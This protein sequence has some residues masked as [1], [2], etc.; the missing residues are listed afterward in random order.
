[1]DFKNQ[2]TSQHTTPLINVAYIILYVTN[3]LI[4]YRIL[5]FP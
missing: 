5:K 4:K 3:F 2:N 1:M